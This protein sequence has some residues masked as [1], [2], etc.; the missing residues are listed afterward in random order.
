[1]C[2]INMDKRYI[3]GVYNMTEEENLRSSNERPLSIEGRQE[4][5]FP[6]KA[7]I[8][9]KL[10]QREMK[11]LEELAEKKE[12]TKVA[13]IRQALRLYQLLDARLAQGEKVLVEDAAGVKTTEL[14]LL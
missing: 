1:M 13:V 6:S 10:S 4:E 8:T 3:L 9:L 12:L 14:M 11:V 7:A 2:C 5:T